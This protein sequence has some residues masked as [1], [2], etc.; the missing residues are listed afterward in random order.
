MKPEIHHY[1]DVETLSLMA[2]E[3]ICTVAAKSARERGAVTFALAGGNTPKPVY[4]CL[5]GPRFG[6]QMPWAHIHLFWGDERC[7]PPDHPD[8]NFGMAFRALISRVPVPLQNV[9]RIPVEM[10]SPEEAAEAY[11]KILRDSFAPFIGGDDATARA[12]SQ[13][14][15]FDLIMLG[16][17]K[18]GHTASLFPGDPCLEEKR[19]W[20]VPVG[21]P[22]GSPPVARITLTLPVI[23][24]ARC[25]LFLVSGA[26]KRDVVRQIVKDPRT[27]SRSY[28]AARIQ[29]EGRVVW[30]LDEE[31]SS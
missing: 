23:N 28:P 25:V 17:G 12:G 18:D 2:A 3:Y 1:P 13:F 10:A 30:F 16:V 27:A 8:S 21:S 26:E 4:E 22:R 19:R 20:V 31:A 29:P 14:P 7:V 24:R 15:R 11:Q 5:A 9:H 6:E